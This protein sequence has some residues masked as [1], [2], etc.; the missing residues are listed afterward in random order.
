MLAFIKDRIYPTIIE[1]C[2]YQSIASLFCFFTMFFFFLF[3]FVNSLSVLAVV[4]YDQN[5]FFVIF[6]AVTQLLALHNMKSWIQV[7]FPRHWSSAVSQ[8]FFSFCLVFCFLWK[9][10]Y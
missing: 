6:V 8:H 2:N 5:R 9:L 1:I 4:Y 7:S 10:K 3:F